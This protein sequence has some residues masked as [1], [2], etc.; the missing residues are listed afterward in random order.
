[1]REHAGFMKRSFAAIVDLALVILITWLLF[2]FPFK[3]VIGNSIH[4]DYKNSYIKPYD[5]ATNKYNGTTNFFGVTTP[6]V[7]AN[8]TGSYD[9]SSKKFTVSGSNVLAFREY[10]NSANSTSLDDLTAF[11][12]LLSSEYDENTKEEDKITAKAYILLKRLGYIY[13]FEKQFPHNAEYEY[14]SDILASGSIN[15]NEYDALVDAFNEALKN[16]YAANIATLINGI[17]VYTTQN[18]SSASYKSSAYK[19]LLSLY[20]S[21]L[22]MKFSD[23]SQ[24]VSEEDITKIK[25]K[26]DEFYNHEK[27][28]FKMDE[29]IVEETN[30]EYGYDTY[31]SVYYDAALL[32]NNEQLPYYEYYNKYS[33]WTI[34]YSLGMFTLLFS[35]YTMLFSGYTLGRRIAKVYLVSGSKENRCNPFLAFL[36]D[37]VFRYSYVIVIGMWSLIVALIVFGAFIIADAIMIRFGGHKTIRDYITLTKVI[38]A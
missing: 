10:V 33:T 3:M 22:K 1:M 16:E 24:T 7:F 37:V 12:E 30:Y 28:I 36:H 19:E 11:N 2:L 38:P 21:E 17:I 13:N 4:K 25:N 20:Q 29:E 26:L 5:E 34:I 9:D 15:Q 8:I 27:V 31:F 18:P 32:L 6:G 14:Y 35:I 23:L